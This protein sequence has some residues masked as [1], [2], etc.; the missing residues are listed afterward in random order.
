MLKCH[1]KL[2]DSLKAKRPYLGSMCFLKFWASM[3]TE[4]IITVCLRGGDEP[5]RRSHPQGL[6]E[7]LRS[8]KQAPAVVRTMF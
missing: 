6:C 2:S 4:P 3:N 5:V 1:K 8:D 7:N